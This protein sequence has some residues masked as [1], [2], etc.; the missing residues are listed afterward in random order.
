M[1]SKQKFLL[2]G[3]ILLAI[4]FRYYQIMYMPGGL[5]PDEAANGLDINSM[6]SGQ[7]QPFYERGN[8]RE[9]L[10][11]YLLWGSISLFGKIPWAHH[12]VSALIG[13]LSVLVCFL[14][15]RRLFTFKVMADDKPGQNKA[16]NIGLLASFLMADYTWHH[17]L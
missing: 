9:A 13:V 4:F 1:S 10:F 14:V 7:L 12:I 2:A 3:V 16:F 11:F 15:T 6:Q 5:F 17:V 8:G